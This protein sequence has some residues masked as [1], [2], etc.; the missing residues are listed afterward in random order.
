MDSLVVIIQQVEKEII[1]DFRAIL[2][3][4]SIEKFKTNKKRTGQRVGALPFV[5]DQIHK[6]F[7]CL[8]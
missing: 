6:G 2:I 7:I 5:L 3:C 4:V 8:L 1:R